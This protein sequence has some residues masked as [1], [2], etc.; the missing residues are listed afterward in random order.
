METEICRPMLE[1][2]LRLFF[3]EKRAS[4]VPRLRGQDLD[5]L[6]RTLVA[7]RSVV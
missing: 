4:P 7:H 5:R 2:Q 6:F 3:T 1:W